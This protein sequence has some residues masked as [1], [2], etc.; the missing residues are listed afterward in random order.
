MQN[1]IKQKIKRLCARAIERTQK[2]RLVEEEYAKKYTK[3]TG[4]PSIAKSASKAVAHHHFDPLYCK[5][6]ANFLAKTIW[7]KIQQGTYKPMPALRFDLPKPGG[8]KRR[9]M[10]FTFPDAAVAAV[11]NRRLTK[12]NLKK[13]SGNSF[14]YRPDRNV[15]DAL[16]KLKSAIRPQRNY[17]LQ[18]D[19]EKYFDTIP[20]AYIKE[21]LNKPDFILLSG[22]EKA[23]IF[24]FLS[25]RSADRLT[26]TSGPFER[27]EIGTPQGS[28]ISLTLANLASHPLD[29]ELE[30]INGQF[31]R[32][33][34]DTVVVSYSYE[35]ATKAYDVFI[36][37]CRKSGL[38]INKQKSP[39]I[40]ILSKME[41]E[42]RSITDFR[43]LGYG[44]CTDG[45][46]MHSTVERRVREKLSRL[47]N[48]YLIHYIDVVPPLAIHRRVGPGYDWDLLGLISEI[49]NILYGGLSENQLFKFIRHGVKLRQM[50]GYMGFYALLERDEARFGHSRR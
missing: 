50:R 49:R 26:Y 22:T 30:A 47:I 9:I 10:Q 42:F 14:A 39:G 31:A 40:C 28:S 45:L 15:F 43:F 20:H 16:L 4:Y 34:D 6:N 25:H 3:R 38:E 32:Y 36:R 1:A 37:H 23:A 41:E 18:L 7:H 19:F 8:G 12:R 2:Q 33:A 21:L 48:L 17:V 24:A 13:Q 11:L 35:D 46:T 29:C 5:R 27:R 44:I